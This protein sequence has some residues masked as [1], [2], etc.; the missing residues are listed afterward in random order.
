MNN[1][2]ST[3]PALRNNS[4]LATRGVFLELSVLCGTDWSTCEN[5]GGPGGDSVAAEYTVPFL[6]YPC[7]RENL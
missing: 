4:L 1:N 5:Y 6:A 3:T 2:T 7:K